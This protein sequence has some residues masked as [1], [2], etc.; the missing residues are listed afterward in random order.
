[1]N[2]SQSAYRSDWR[3]IFT[4]I[5]EGHLRNA[6][7]EKCPKK[8]GAFIQENQELGN[9]ILGVSLWNYDKGWGSGRLE[10]KRPH[11][12]HMGDVIYFTTY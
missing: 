6:L 11:V 8:I 2:L 9:Y 12:G 5:F 3:M 7:G 10:V 1:M 4:R